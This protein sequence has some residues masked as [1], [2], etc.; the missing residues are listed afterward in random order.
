MCTRFD[1]AQSVIF[2]SRFSTAYSI[3]HVRAVRNVFC[4]LSVTRHFSLVLGRNPTE[5]LVAWADADFMGCETTSRSTT[6]FV[7]TLFGS[8]VS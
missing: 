6:G 4:Y 1:L 7:V 5:G 2:L 8:A 3:Q